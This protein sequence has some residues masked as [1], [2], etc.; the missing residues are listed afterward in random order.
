[1]IYIKVQKKLFFYFECILF[2]F[3]N[4]I[5]Q[6]IFFANLFLKISL[7]LKKKNFTKIKYLLSDLRKSFNIKKVE[8]F[9][10][11]HDEN[12]NKKNFFPQLLICYLNS[13]LN[14]DFEKTFRLKNILLKN[15]YLYKKKS[16]IFGMLD[17]KGLNREKFAKKINLFRYEY[18]NKD[19]D[20]KNYINGKKVALVGPAQCDLHLGSEIDT[21]DIVIRPN[22][23]EN[24][25][26]PFSIYGSK[27]N[28]A[29]YNSYRVAEKKEDII[30]IYK[31][32]DWIVFKSTN[33]IKKLGLVDHNNRFRV[34][35]DPIDNFLFEDPM[36]PQ[37]IIYDIAAFKPSYFKL[38]HFDLY[39]SKNYSDSYKN[40]HLDKQNISNSL[41]SHGPM[42]CFIFMK[43][44]HKLN[45]FSTDEET[46]KVLNLNEIQYARNL[47][48]NYGGLKYEPEI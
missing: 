15:E 17:L 40:W 1:M 48:K 16:N 11:N 34:T 36:L 30:K 28:V 32:L 13:R 26:E 18:K 12:L 37:R 44:F 23:K 45:F 8:D 39:N 29:Y 33:D 41:R 22:F 9:I 35:K 19:Y 2:F 20:F 25:N 6:D 7:E 10:F 14:D 24:S 43:I 42:S 27:T 5:Y 38:F 31:K 3:Y 46:E 4:L 21:F 47:D